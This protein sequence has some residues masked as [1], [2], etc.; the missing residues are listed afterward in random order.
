MESEGLVS[1]GEHPEIRSPI[2]QIPSARE[3]EISI[4]GQG[5]LRRSGPAGAPDS[6]EIEVAPAPVAQELTWL[7][8]IT[9]AILAIGLF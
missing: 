9:G 6:P 8:A 5:R 7:L 1:L 3:F 4:S 2:F